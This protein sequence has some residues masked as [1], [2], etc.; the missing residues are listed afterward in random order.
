[1]LRTPLIGLELFE[2]SLDR[3]PLNKNKID[4]STTFRNIV[5]TANSLSSPVNAG[6][7]YSQRDKEWWQLGWQEAP[8]ETLLTGT[9]LCD[10]YAWQSSWVFIELL[11]PTALPFCPTLCTIVPYSQA[12]G[13]CLSSP[14]PPQR[15]SSILLI[16]KRLV[17]SVLPGNFIIK[18]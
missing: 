15:Y 17:P 18:C 1:M 12:S 4:W 2:P 9:P 14:P 5:F 10:R 8:L 13:I 6:D 3:L 16:F 7:S 11:L